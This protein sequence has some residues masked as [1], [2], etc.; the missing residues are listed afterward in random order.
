MARVI[1]YISIYTPREYRRGAA[2]ESSP[3]KALLAPDADRE[4]LRNVSESQNTPYIN[5]FDYRLFFSMIL[6]VDFSSELSN[7]LI[8]TIDINL[9][10]SN[11]TRSYCP[12]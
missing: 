8:N 2:N 4:N 3:R 1:Q 11:S 12:N 5:D 10:K 6:F 7:A 9:N